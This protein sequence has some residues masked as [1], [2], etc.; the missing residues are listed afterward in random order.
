MQLVI[1]R[2]TTMM[3]RESN[4]LNN[5]WWKLLSQFDGC[6]DA[7]EFWKIAKDSEALTKEVRRRVATQVLNDTGVQPGLPCPRK[8]S[9]IM[10]AHNLQVP[11]LAIPEN[12]HRQIYPDTWAR[13]AI[14][15]K[16]G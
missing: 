13:E 10:V 11:T 9:G 15:P 2:I 14:V 12:M 3:E 4:I 7:R 1:K 6:T 16:R 5:E 8:D